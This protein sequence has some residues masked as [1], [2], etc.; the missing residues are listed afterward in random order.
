MEGKGACVGVN[1]N[2]LTPRDFSMRAIDDDM[3][4]T[5]KQ[6]I[7]SNGILRPIIVADLL[8]SF[9]NRPLQNFIIDG[10]SLFNIGC[11]LGY[12][13]FNVMHLGNLSYEECI[14]KYI[15]LNIHQNPMDYIALSELLNKLIDKTSINGLTKILPFDLGSIKN[16]I[17]LTTFD[18][19]SFQE[20]EGVDKSQTTLF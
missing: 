10:M 20:I 17:N 9:D 18:W 7:I 16:L 19:D 8:G 1:H 12:S 14:K 13:E 2:Q 3:H 6:S 5:L 15:Q 11:E 4:K